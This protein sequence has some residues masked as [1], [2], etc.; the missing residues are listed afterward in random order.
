[1]IVLNTNFY[2]DSNKLTTGLNWQPDPAGQF[3]WMDKVLNEIQGKN[4]K[5][6]IALMR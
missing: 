4:Q 3:A 2:Y 6:R 1:M 5:V